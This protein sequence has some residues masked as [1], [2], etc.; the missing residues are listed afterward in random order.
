MDLFCLSYFTSFSSLPQQMILT[1]FFYFL[2]LRPISIGASILSWNEKR[3]RNALSLVFSSLKCIAGARIHRCCIF[4]NKM[5]ACAGKKLCPSLL[6]AIFLFIERSSIIIIII[7]II[8]F[9]F[10][11]INLNASFVMSE[12]WNGFRGKRKYH[13]YVAF[14]G[15]FVVIIIHDGVRL[16]WYI[17]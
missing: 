1:N 9:I 13:I 11:S 5:A 15:C 6:F 3:K 10:S 12:K 7:M 17:E 4:E 16:W 8:R 2:F 14:N